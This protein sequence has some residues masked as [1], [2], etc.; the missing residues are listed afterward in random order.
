MKVQLRKED[1][2]TP[3]CRRKGQER[4]GQLDASREKLSLKLDPTHVLDSMT[5][6]DMSHLMS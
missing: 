4:G 2:L 5:L 6:S 1:R 3:S